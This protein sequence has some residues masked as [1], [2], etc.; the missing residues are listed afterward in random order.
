MSQT[1]RE[2]CVEAEV[3]LRPLAVCSDQKSTARS[4]NLDEDI[5]AV[6]LALPATT[7]VAVL[8][9]RLAQATG[10]R[11]AMTVVFSTY[12]SIDV[13]SKAHSGAGVSPFDVIVCDEAHRT[14]GT[15]LADQDESA[16][17]RVH[18]SDY[19]RG[20]R[21]LYMTATPRIYDDS[22]KARAG[23]ANAVLASMDDEKLFGPEFHRLGFGDAVGRDLLSDY[24]V[25]VLAVDETAVAKTFQS[26]LA[27]DGELTLDD[28][29]KIVGCWNG[30]AKRGQAEH[31]FATDPAPMRRAVAFSGTIK[32]SKRIESLFSEIVD[33][34]VGSH[35][36]AASGDVLGC[37]IRHVDGTYNAL[38]RNTR[39]DWLRASPTDDTCRI[40]TNARCLSEGVDVLA[41]DAVMFLSPRKSIVDIVQ[42]VGRVMR[43]SPGKQYGYIILPIGI[44]ENL[45][46]EQ[47]L[48]DNKRYAAVWEILQALRAHD[49]R[50]DAMVNRID[51][52]SKRDE[53]INI[54]GVPG[55][56]G[57]G[58]GTPAVQGT[59]AL[60][61]ASLDEWRDKIYAKI[62]AKV[63][64]RRYWEDWA[65]DVAD[66]A[67]RHITRIT[68][69]LD[70]PA[71]G[72]TA[73]FEAFLE[74]LRGNLNDNITR[75]DAIDM[76]AQHLITRPVFDALFGGYDFTAHNPVAQGME[77][78]LAALDEHSV[79]SEDETLEKFYE[80]V[81]MRVRGIDTADGRQEIIRQLYDRFFATAF[82]R[83][84]AK[85]GIAYTPVEVV[86]FILRSAE[87][88][89]RESFGVGLTD[90][91]VHILDGFTGT[92]TFIVR[93]LQL[94]LID[95]E[96]LARKYSNELHANEILLLA[97]YI[98]AAN[99]ET[100]YQ[101]VR[102]D[103]HGEGEYQPFPGLILTDTFQS[104]EHDD[105]PDLDVFPENNERVERL[106]KLDIRVIVGNPPWSAG[107]DSAN[108]NN[109][110]EQ[111]A[112][113]DRSI[114]DTYAT[115]SSAHLKNK[116]YDS[117]VRAIRW[118]TLRIKDRGVVAFVT[119]G[120]WLDANVADGM[121]KTLAEEFAGIYIFNLRG[122]QRTAGEQSRKEGGKIFGS[123]S[124]ATV[125]ITLL[126]KD[127]D[128]DGQAQIHYRD[129][130]EY[131]TR[132]QKLGIVDDVKSVEHLGGSIL[133]P[134][135][136]G[137]WTQR[138][139][140]RFETFEALRS[141][142]APRSLFTMHTLGV[143]TNR[144]AWV[145]N[146]S[147]AQVL[148][149]TAVCTDTYESD[150]HRLSA[151]KPAPTDLPA[152]VT[153]DPRK[154]SWANGLFQN[155]RSGIEARVRPDAVRVALYRP[156]Q[157]QHLYYD[158][159]W[160]NTRGQRARIFPTPRQANVGLYIV[161]KSSAVPFSVL[162]VD[163]LP[164]LHATGAGSGGQFFPRWIYERLEDD[165]QAM[166]VSIDSDVVDGYRRVDNITDHAVERF[167]HVYNTGLS[168]DD[169]F[170]YIYGLLH[171]P[172]YRRAYAAD[173]K[174]VWPRIPFVTDAAPYISAGRS[175][176]DL[177][178]R[179]E[180]TE[181]HPLDGLSAQPPPD[182]DAYAF[183]RVERMRFGKPTPAQ[184]TN[185]L[186]ADRSTLIYNGHITLRDIPEDIHRYEI[187][188]RSAVEWIM[189]RYRVTTDTPSG[190]RNDPNEWSREVGNPRYI[191]DLIA[192]IVTVRLR[193]ME[194]VDSLPHWRSVTPKDLRV[195]R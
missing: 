181:P 51:L 163:S 41:L 48:K 172:D 175:L 72:V 102:T 115:R 107:Q 134:N 146:S 110:N 162:A 113:L 10:D 185:G 97:Y 132:E 127:P 114:A 92:G 183:Y 28:A 105:K 138:R 21:R 122:N 71:T 44:P 190:I 89:L 106:K 9:S 129:V 141:K 131:L 192:R 96:D 76:L 8:E 100:A 80:S 174:M 43:K 54:I 194:I 90:E 119:N 176:I 22:S 64:S 14:T 165:D 24:K 139:D 65:K 101:D 108:D 118:A 160:N 60:S 40:L 45:T 98:A 25:L 148:A 193:T 32:G 4:K 23:E 180:S 62:V 85:L 82:P 39:L 179:Y 143:A 88:A 11:D 142:D 73:E 36:L 38:E 7:N 57:P 178:V 52:T 158:P 16:F 6:D 20:D 126:V 151:A 86:D 135:A 2:W 140:D 5:S 91:G 49:E 186:R 34:Y 87:W 112:S 167:R 35:D 144:D 17:V 47:A 171:S 188:A 137:D 145:Y 121:R 170:F 74:G 46:P 59:L 189:D 182:V 93:L 169:V 68:A 184:K 125:A 3:P 61:F 128:H 67:Q 53:R 79:A 195:I 187:G 50:F 56:D 37:D 116:L 30:L 191:L 78:M 153:S 66:I 95:T 58:N 123:G 1:L 83:S 33:T 156:W 168:K 81:R 147:S 157:K 84:V 130:G 164:D 136:A 27:A 63:G 15:T 77:R 69:L 31:S 177:H 99:I 117:Y 94:G 13:V 161:G 42:S 173:L 150:R 152:F 103:A 133:E 19:I 26:Q 109:A 120:G 18:D 124:R 111:Y 29:A 12:Q 154:I 70:D 75:G 159:L 104:W 166:F 55:P 149:N 155:L